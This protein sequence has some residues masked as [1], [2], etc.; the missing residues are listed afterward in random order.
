[1]Q[2]LTDDDGTITL[3]TGNSLGQVQFWKAQTGTLQQSVTQSEYKADVLQIVASADKT[4][5]FASGVDS[6]V[7]CLEQ[8]RVADLAWK[9]TTAQRCLCSA[10]LLSTD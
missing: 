6:R 8:M 9:W 7:I 1:M 10:S 5:V 3:V 4:K 2:M